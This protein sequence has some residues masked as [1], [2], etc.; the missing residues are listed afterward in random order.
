MLHPHLWPDTATLSQDGH[1]VI[2]GCD[3]VALAR[4]HGTPLYLLDEATFRACCRA[5]RTACAR[6]YPG[7][8]V[9]HYA[10][11]ALLTTAVA[12]LVAEEGLGLDVV[13]GGELYVALRAGFPAQRMHLHGNAKPRAELEQALEAGIGTIVVDSLDELDLL[14]RLTTGRVAPQ[15][16]ML[17]LSPGITADTHAHIETGSAGSKFGL[18]LAA[19]DAAAARLAATPGLRL[20]GLHAHLGSQILDPAPIVRA[21]AVLLDC[22]ARLRDRHAILVDAISPGGG[23]GVPYTPAQPTPDLESYV[24]AVGGALQSGCVARGLP[25]PRLVLEPG[26]SIVARA[27]VAVYEIIATKPLT[28]EGTPAQDEHPAIDPLRPSA[29]VRYLH[30]DGG[31]ADN[32][33]PA[34]YGARYTALLANRASAQ[35]EE[36]VHV[37]GRYCE[38]GDVLLRDVALPRAGPGDLLAVAVAGA[39]TLS[40]ASTYNL[41]PRP[42]LLL[43]GDGRARVI[44][45]RETYAD[46]AARDM[47]LADQPATSTS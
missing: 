23:L 14:A 46:L 11:K 20:A 7:P 26:R 10:S 16:I 31:M 44:Q 37:A 3:T 40:M 17:R 4:N 45:R 30:V 47:P 8:A 32:I 43:V 28:D 6:Q 36:I 13:S 18:P 33:R 27:G 5:Y 15:A 25:L 22:A 12:Q 21:I 41:V 9:V 1:L 29:A 2:G 24:A 38:S 34:L 39:Y 42:A 19:L 35:P